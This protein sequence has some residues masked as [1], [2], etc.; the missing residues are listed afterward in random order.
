M[1][2]QYL[3]VLGLSGDEVLGQ[4]DD[5]ILMGGIGGRGHGGSDDAIFF[6]G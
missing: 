5:A 4:G 6:V 2:C 1:I 3:R